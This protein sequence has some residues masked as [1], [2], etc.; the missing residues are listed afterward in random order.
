MGSSLSRKNSTTRHYLPRRG[1]YFQALKVTRGTER[2][3]DLSGERKAKF[4]FFW[5]FVKIW[6]ENPV[7]VLC[8]EHRVVTKLVFV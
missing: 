5:Y 3:Q 4:G 2:I 6:V 1:K 7:F 8:K